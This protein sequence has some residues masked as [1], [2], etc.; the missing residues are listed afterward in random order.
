M[1]LVASKNY[2]E[3]TTVNKLTAIKGNDT[4]KAAAQDLIFD[5]ARTLKV[6]ASQTV[7]VSAT[8]KHSADGGMVIA[9]GSE[10]VAVG[11]TREVKTLGDY[12]CNIGGPLVR[13]VGGAKVVV[14]VAANNRHV[15]AAST[16]VVG[17]AW[18]EAG[19]MS[20]VNVLG[21]NN[22]SSGA[23]NITTGKYELDTSFLNET[24]ATKS[25][26][27]A[28]FVLHA[29]TINL[30]TG[31]TNILASKAVI[32]GKS[33]VTV[34]AGGATIEVKPGV[35]NVTGAVNAGGDVITNGKAEHE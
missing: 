22:L 1:K 18:L 20:A 12:A 13:C 34:K 8:R 30:T 17:G 10:L 29:S 16:V 31:A 9:A 26:K 23:T 28:S 14:A 24:C 33:S 6:D 19:V 25:E 21:V 5:S 4:R 15:N 11:G 2:N 35:V 3:K 32:V 7:S 27:G